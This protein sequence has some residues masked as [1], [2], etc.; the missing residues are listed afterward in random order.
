MGAVVVER[1]Q[2]ERSRWRRSDARSATTW[3]RPGAD[4]AL[5][6]RQA[7]AFE[8]F[9]ESGTPRIGEERAGGWDLWHERGGR[10]P[11]PEG[12]YAPQTPKILQP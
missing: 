3:R 11:S 2:R 5:T 6:C 8:R 4:P 10:S 7:R 9:W 12:P 1:T